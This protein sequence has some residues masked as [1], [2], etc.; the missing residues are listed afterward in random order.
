[1]SDKITLHVPHG[2]SGYG[3]TYWSRYAEHCLIAADRYETENISCF[4]HASYLV[5]GTYVHLLIAAGRGLKIDTTEVIDTQCNGIVEE[6]WN[7]AFRIYDGYW[8]AIGEQDEFDG[9]VIGREL[10]ISGDSFEKFIGYA[11][12]AATLD[13]LVKKSSGE[14]WVYDYKT[15]GRT[16]NVYDGGS[17]KLQRWLYC[18]AAN[19][20]GYPATR[21]IN[22]QIVKNQKILVHDYTF[23]PPTPVEKRALVN[24]L[25][26]AG[27]QKS[28][29]VRSPHL[30]K[31]NYC[32]FKHT[33]LHT[34]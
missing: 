21:F 30:S 10:K 8:E 12:I 33:C 32:I 11:P 15:S 6:M 2:G 34:A 20:A 27:K 19:S 17:Y 3:N 25:H 26:M 13:V 24:Y 7:D 4:E 14:Y 9:E 31:C 23:L 29:G 1:M 28:Q 18:L 5:L 16:G 22:R